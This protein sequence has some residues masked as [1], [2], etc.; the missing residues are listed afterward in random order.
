MGTEAVKDARISCWAS[1]H[2]L[3]LNR[4][5]SVSHLPVKPFAVNEQIIEVCAV[6]ARGLPGALRDIKVA[7]DKILSHEVQ[8]GGWEA[9]GEE[10]HT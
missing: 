6:W 2:H 5:N 7:E 1:Q 10:V 3:L 9:G 4:N 8:F